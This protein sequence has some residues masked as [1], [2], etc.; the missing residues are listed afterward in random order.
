M[1]K[2]NE[3]RIS[4]AIED[5]KAGGMTLLVSVEVPPNSIRLEDDGNEQKDSDFD[6]LPSKLEGRLS[7][8]M[9]TWARIKNEAMKQG[10]QWSQGVTKTK[11][12]NTF[13]SSKPKVT[14]LHIRHSGLVDGV[15]KTFQ[16]IDGPDG[17]RLIGNIDDRVDRV[18][19]RDRRFTVAIEGLE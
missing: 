11:V 18:V 9:M 15:D 7:C 4:I 6:L 3:F 1:N 14:V 19:V 5:P 17:S 16:I 10:A 2:V 8:S 13:W 12:P